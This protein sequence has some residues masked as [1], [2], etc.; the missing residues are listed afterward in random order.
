M[1]YNKTIKLERIPRTAEAMQWDVDNTADILHFL[2][3]H[4]KTGEFRDHNGIPIIFVR[5]VEHSLEHT[6][7]IG[8]WLLEGMDGKLRWYTDANKRIMYQEISSIDE[9]CDR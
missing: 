3:A 8:D 6:L 2:D 4:Q 9:G 5:S 1:D 7:Y